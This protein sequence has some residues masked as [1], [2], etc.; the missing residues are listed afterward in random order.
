MTNHFS[1]YHDLMPPGS[2]FAS[3]NLKYMKVGGGDELTCQRRQKKCSFLDAWIQI[4]EFI[5]MTEDCEI[6]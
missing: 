5:L 3:Q 6:Y 4:H 2:A 1:R